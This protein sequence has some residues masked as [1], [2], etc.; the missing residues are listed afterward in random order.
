MYAVPQ[1]SANAK[2]AWDFLNYL[3]EDEQQLMIFNEASKYRAYG[4]PFSSTSLSSQLSTSAVT[5]NY[6][7]P[8]INGAP[9]SKTGIITAKS[10]N[11]VE[12]KAMKDAI[13][14]VITPVSD[15]KLTPEEALNVAK[16]SIVAN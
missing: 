5:N 11:K 13:N 4:A 12:E 9:F 14:A 16:E 7:K 6:L 15:L 3:S 10:G 8:V 2:V 1:G